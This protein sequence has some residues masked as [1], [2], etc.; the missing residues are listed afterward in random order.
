MQ[1][2]AVLHA[3]AELWATGFLRASLAA[4]TEPY[5]VAGV[6]ND[7]AKVAQARK[8]VVRRDGGPQRGLF[9]FARLTVRIW[10]PTEQEAS[11][12]ARLVRALLLASPGNGPVVA[13]ESPSG[14]MGVPDASG[15]QKFLSV[16]VKM[17]GVDL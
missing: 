2:P 8:V 3:D 11:D 12:L 5:A 10:A 16:E 17:R 4:R 9:D 1:P 7:K 6:G 15:P 14:P 13:A